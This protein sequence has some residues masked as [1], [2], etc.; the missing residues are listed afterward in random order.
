MRAPFAG[1]RCDDCERQGDLPLVGELV[2]HPVPTVEPATA[3][4]TIPVAV[5]RPDGSRAG[6][7]A[8][9]GET[10]DGVAYG[11]ALRGVHGDV[12]WRCDHLHRSTQGAVVCATREAFRRR[13]R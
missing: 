4:A 10:S 8:A 12:L 13:D 6:L 7:E 3:R 5:R 2:G 9:T 11:A 1:R